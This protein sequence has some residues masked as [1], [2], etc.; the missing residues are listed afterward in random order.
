MNGF[1]QVLFL[2]CPNYPS[3]NLLNDRI[4]GAQVSYGGRPDWGKSA[5]IGLAV[6]GLTLSF[7]TNT[8]GSS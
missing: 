1:N 8:S 4:G 3:Y 5:I 6:G 2:S 7:T